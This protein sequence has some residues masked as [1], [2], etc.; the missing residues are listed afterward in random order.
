MPPMLTRP[1]IRPGVRWRRRGA[2][3][4]LHHLFVVGFATVAI[5]AWLP[6]RHVVLAEPG[7]SAPRELVAGKSAVR[8]DQ[9]PDTL[10]LLLAHI[11]GME[12]ALGESEARV[13]RLADSLVDLRGRIERDG[14]ERN[15][16][17][18][19][20]RGTL[21]SLLDSLGIL[22]D[23]DLRIESSVI[24]LR[25]EGEARSS[26][27]ATRLDGLA[28]DLGGVETDMAIWRAQV[29][30][31][32]QTAR[33]AIVT[34]QERRR[35]GDSRSVLWVVF[36]AGV[37]VSVFGFV[38][39]R[40]RAG[41]AALDSRVER[42]KSELDRK[43]ATAAEEMGGS[44]TGEAREL[45]REQLAAL[46]RVSATLAALEEARAA[47]APQSPEPDH[48]LA[49]GVCNE[50]NRIENN[51]LAMDSKVRGHKQLRGC[52]RRIK[53]NLH[54]EGY[55]ITELRGRRYDVGMHVNADLVEDESLDPGQRIISR[56]SRPEV[57]FRDSIIQSAAVK[58][59]VGF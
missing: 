14:A 6:S 18:A 51:L 27:M 10:E 8:Q 50:L 25:A 23:R 34:E 45:L 15:L 54:V 24:S 44:S 42:V 1:S 38:S 48:D 20:L 2:V 37:V 12:S 55:E 21:L 41:T 59:S 31:S 39:W 46:E 28:D 35:T 52:V 26:A 32:L 4:V 11:R 9:Q 43:I 22:T 40:A 3:R 7:P 17:I 5:A 33:A 19:E 53:E 36:A 13:A 47:G 49:L 30:D 29:L 58:V 57:R 16:E 56:V